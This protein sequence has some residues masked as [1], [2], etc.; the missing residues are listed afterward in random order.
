M[1]SV[2]SSLRKAFDNEIT[3]LIFQYYNVPFS[4]KLT[5][6]HISLSLKPSYKNYSEIGYIKLWF[7][8][9]LNL[10]KIKY[11]DIFGFLLSCHEIAYSLIITFKNIFLQIPLLKNYAR[12]LNYCR[13][14]KNLIKF[15]FF[16]EKIATISKN[17][18][19]RSNTKSKTEWQISYKLASKKIIYYL[20]MT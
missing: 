3:N 6:Q 11:P 18:R 16:K 9:N 5:L 4:S 17:I 7:H 8:R 15:N 19:K 14:E 13:C 10:S 20:C 1:K 2:D 12:V